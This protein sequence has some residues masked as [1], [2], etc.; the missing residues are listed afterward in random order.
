MMAMNI[1][2]TAL[3]LSEEVFLKVT[4]LRF[5]KA[6]PLHI[7]VVTI[8]AQ[9]L[10]LLIVMVL[11]FLIYMIIVIQIHLELKLKKDQ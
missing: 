4:P 10:D 9:P 5:K 8:I 6:I 2:M 7:M 3:K 1:H 11:M